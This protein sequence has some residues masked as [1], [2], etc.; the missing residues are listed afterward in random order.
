MSFRVFALKEIDK[1]LWIVDKVR[2]QTSIETLYPLV[3]LGLPPHVFIVQIVVVAIEIIGLQIFLNSR[4]LVLSFHCNKCL[5]TFLGL[6]EITCVL[7]L[8]LLFCHC[9]CCCCCCLFYLCQTS[10]H[11]LF[12]A[13]LNCI[14]HNWMSYPLSM[15]IHYITTASISQSIF[16]QMETLSYSSIEQTKKSYANTQSSHSLFY[17]ISSLLFSCYSTNYSFSTHYF[18]SPFIAVSIQPSMCT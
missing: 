16:K 11:A 6:I 4:Q 12:K 1:H 5:F 13:I 17:Q 2:F 14:L 7:R 8:F 9:C 3:F 10:Q 15:R 18:I